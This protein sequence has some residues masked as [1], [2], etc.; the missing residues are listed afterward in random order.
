MMKGSL[1]GNID[2]IFLCGVGAELPWPMCVKVLRCLQTVVSQVYT[3]SGDW[4]LYLFYYTVRPLSCSWG[5]G[6]VLDMCRCHDKVRPECAYWVQ[7]SLL[8]L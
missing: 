1:L 2:K 5:Q 3:R 8:L 7:R 4:S 6:S